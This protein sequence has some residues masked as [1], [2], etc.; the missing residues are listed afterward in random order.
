MKLNDLVILLEDRH[1]GKSLAEQGQPW[2]VIYRGLVASA[3]NLFRSMD[4]VTCSRKFAIDHAEHLSVTEV[5]PTI[6]I[7]AMVK[8]DKVFDAYNPGEYFY[9]GPEIK[10]TIIKQFKAFE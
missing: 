8:G 4:Y 3:G 10:G 1:K 6:V 7:R 9:D 2:V 5:E